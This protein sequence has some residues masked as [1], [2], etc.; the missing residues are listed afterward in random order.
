MVAREVEAAEEVED[1][2]DEDEQQG[3]EHHP[4]GGLAVAAEEIHYPGGEAVIG[5][6]RHLQAAHGEL[7]LDIVAGHGEISLRID[8]HAKYATAF[9][10]D[11]FSR[12]GIDLD[13]DI[14][15]R[16]H[17]K[18]EIHPHIVDVKFFDSFL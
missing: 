2:A 4:H 8:V 17:I 6:E 10:L 12:P 9:S 7:L 18:G 11:T 5:P 3:E 15:V 16:R 13:F 1:A 14:G